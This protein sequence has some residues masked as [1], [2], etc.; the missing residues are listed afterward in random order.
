MN[1]Y[2]EAPPLRLITEEVEKKIPGQG[3]NRPE[4]TESVIYRA[5][6]HGLGPTQ[7]PKP[8]KGPRRGAYLCGPWS[9][10]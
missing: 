9:R 3:L 7:W 5:T 2:P 1:V 6:D 10:L 8:K 4:A